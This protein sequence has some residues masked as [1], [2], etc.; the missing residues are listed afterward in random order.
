MK[1][2]IFVAGHNGMVGSAICRLLSL[3]ADLN[4]I[5]ANR[6]KLDL[7]SQSSVEKFFRNNKF[8]EVYLCAAKVGGIHANNNKPAEFIYENLVIQSNI[9]HSSFVMN[10]QK[11]LFLGSSCIY[12]KFSKQPI[13][14]T[15]LLNGALE[16]TNEPYAIS[17]IAGIKLC[18]SYNRQY[19][20]DFRSVMPTNLYGP[21]DN[22]HDLNAHVIPALISRF[23]NAKLDNLND[24][25]VWGS[26]KPRRE[27]LYVDDMASACIHIMSISKEKFSKISP[28][29]CSHINIGTGVDHS[30]KDLSLIIKKITQFNGEIIFDKSFPDGTEKKLLNVDKLSN[31]GWKYEI[32]LKRGIEL[33]YKWYLENEQTIRMK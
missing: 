31:L 21:G 13:E 30:I 33:S 8:D 14:E 24:I 5:T 29:R 18:E 26:G 4:I 17:K 27:F 2:T 19:G 1:K 11:L 10:V 22:F 25:K 12:P 7:L 28:T 3:D 32:D 9:I 15:E 23:H 20:T 16:L 6:D